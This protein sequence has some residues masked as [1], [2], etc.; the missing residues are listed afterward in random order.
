MWNRIEYKRDEMVGEAYYLHDVNSAIKRRQAMFRCKC[1]NKFIAQ[2]YKVKT[3][4]NNYSSGTTS[5]LN[6]DNMVYVEGGTFMM[7]SNEGENDEKPVHEVTV[8]SFY[9]GKYEVTVEEFDKFIKATGYKTDAEK[10]GFSW[11]WNGRDW[12][13]K[14][15]VNWRYGVEGEVRGKSEKRHPVIYVSWNDA[16]AY[17]KWKGG[18]LPT[19]AEWKYAA[20]G[21]NKSEGYKYAGS[22]NIDEVAWYGNN[23]GNKTHTVGT[24]APNELGIYDFSGNVL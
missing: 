23:S 6:S 1:G 21:G 10:S 5:G 13:Q 7:G 11:R 18:R 20:F 8:N 16:I 3:G 24:K 9:I 14:N 12:E 22:N 4:N 19:E 17:A 15:G 2:V